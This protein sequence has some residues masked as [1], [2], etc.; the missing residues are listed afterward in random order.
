MMLFYE[1]DVVV[2]DDVIVDDDDVIIVVDDDDDDALS[3]SRTKGYI[4]IIISY[5]LSSDQYLNEATNVSSSSSSSLSLS[6][7]SLS[8]SSL[9]R[10]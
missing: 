10:Y 2:D 7:S 5:P 4:R 3:I 1:Y 9:W 6:S 8:L